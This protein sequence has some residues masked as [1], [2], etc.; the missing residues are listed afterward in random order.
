MLLL[1]YPFL[2]FPWLLSYE[3]TSPHIGSVLPR[4]LAYCLPIFPLLSSPGRARD[5]YF[6]FLFFPSAPPKPNESNSSAS[7]PERVILWEPTR[8]ILL[9]LAFFSLDNNF[10]PQR[11]SESSFV[12]YRLVFVVFFPSHTHPAAPLTPSTVPS[13]CVHSL[14][15]WPQS[16]PSCCRVHS[17][18]LSWLV[19]FAIP[20]QVF[21]TRA[22]GSSSSSL[23]LNRLTLG[24]C[25]RVGFVY[26]S[27]MPLG[28]SAFLF[29]ASRSFFALSP[30]LLPHAIG[31]TLKHLCRF[32]F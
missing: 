32:F 11:S 21:R 1:L 18:P 27:L 25:S 24:T 20:E 9:R 22:F 31:P 12:P 13:H 10:P 2:L 5:R 3:T 15:S 8:F 30:H 6:F 16:L 26:H 23:P 7:T 19:F 17:L 14:S 29:S 28:F 4:A